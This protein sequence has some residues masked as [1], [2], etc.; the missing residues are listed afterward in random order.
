MGRGGR[1]TREVIVLL[2]LLVQHRRRN[3]WNVAARIAFASHVYLVVL[4]PK[5][6]LPVLEELDKVL[7]N[8]LLGRGGDFAN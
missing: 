3:V 5:G 1:L 2:V 6:L 7:G 4:D 8:L